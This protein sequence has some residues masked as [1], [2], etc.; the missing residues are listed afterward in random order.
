LPLVQQLSVDVKSN[1]LEGNM[2]LQDLQQIEESIQTCRRI[3]NGMLALARDA[4]QGNIQANFRRALDSTL[5]VLKDGLERQRIRLDVRLQ[6]IVPNIHVG[7][8]DLEQLLL[9]LLTNAR[10]AMP[11][12]GVLAIMTEVVG[13]KIAIVVHD[14]G[15]GIPTDALSRIQEPF[16]TTK[17]NGSGLGLSICRSIIWNAGGR[18]EIASQPGVGTKV[19][20]LLPIVSDNVPA[21]RL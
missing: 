4:S 7:Q 2:L 10:D 17:K 5:A 9:N 19:R 3:F 20:V 18:M 21:N 16:F 12:G 6:D 1:Q 13:E 11:S 14:N 15:C 8:G